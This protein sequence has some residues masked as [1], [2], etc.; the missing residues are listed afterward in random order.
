MGEWCADK[1]R[2]CQAWRDEGLEISTTSNECAKFYDATLRQLVSWMDLIARCLAIGMHALGTSNSVHKEKKFKENLEKL[3]DDAKTANKREQ[4]HVKAIYNF[5]YGKMQSACV[6]WEKILAEHPTDLMALK[7]SHDGYFFLGDCHRKK[8]SVERVIGKWKKTEPCYNYLHGMLAFGLEEC[9]EYSRA[10]KEARYGLELQRQDCWATH[11]IAHCYE[12]NSKFEE[13][14]NFLEST[15]ADWEPCYILACHNFWHNALFYIDKGDYEAALR[16]YDE[17]IER[18]CRSNAML[19]IVDA[20][21]ML[22]RFE[23]EKVDVGNRWK[24]LEPFTECHI[25]DHV[26]AFNDAHM[27]MIVS[28]LENDDLLEKHQKSMG[29]FVRNGSGGNH[30]VTKDIGDQLS[31][32]I[33]AFNKK[34]Y[35]EAFDLIYPIRFEIIQIGGSHAQR[36]VFS[37]VLI[38]S[39]LRSKD[40]NQRRHAKQLIDERNA[41]KPN[42]PLA[43]RIVAHHKDILFS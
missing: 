34:K 19:D 21:S 36:D 4:H 23:M 17:E 29:E 20:A 31:E 35:E 40:C 41:L 16:V 30:R 2:D 25:G 13:G 37:Q 38:H 5:A 7:F 26:L 33:I 11:A 39:A 1:L 8:D 9:G 12:M 42:S 28:N 10:E 32:G 6:E 22:C 3:I 18:R 27:S 43:D 24:K 15:V 14:I